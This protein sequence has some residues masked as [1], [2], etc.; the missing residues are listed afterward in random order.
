[1]LIGLATGTA[2][3]LSALPP[4]PLPK[5][6]AGNSWKD[7]KKLGDM[8]KVLVESFNKNIEFYNLHPLQ[9]SEK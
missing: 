6:S 3:L 2:A 7:R 8:Q 4:P 9:V 5:L 1:M